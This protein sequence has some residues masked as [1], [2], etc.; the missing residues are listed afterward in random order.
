L[1]T[2]GV[3]QGEAYVC[4]G[5]WLVLLIGCTV[6]SASSAEPIAQRVWK[7]YANASSLQIRAVSR[8]KELSLEANPSVY[9]NV[10]PAQWRQVEQEVQRLAGQEIHTELAV[11]RP[12]RLFIEER[13]AFG[14]FRSVCDGRVWQVQQQGGR[15]NRLAAPR[16]LQQMSEARYHRW[17]GLERTENTDVLRQL[18]LGAPQLKQKMLSAKEQPA[19]RAN[20]KLLTWSEPVSYEGLK[21][22]GTVTC[23]VDIS[24]ALIRWVEYRYHVALDREVWMNVVIVQQWDNSRISRPPPSSRFRLEK[25]RGATTR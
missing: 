23:L 9:D 13:S 19:Q 16:T 11:M 21:G 15:V 20:L 6:L 2:T 4:T 25:V 3:S 17:L 14:W 22:Q 10:D 12:N 24:T 7:R 1:T 8:F 18:A 5:A